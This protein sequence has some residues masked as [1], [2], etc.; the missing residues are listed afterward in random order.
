[1]NWRITY[2]HLGYKQTGSLV[3]NLLKAD[4][5]KTGTAAGERANGGLIESCDISVTPGLTPYKIQVEVLELTEFTKQKNS[6][7]SEANVDHTNSNKKS[8]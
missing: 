6:V 1:M 8:T 7:Q 2:S 5:P 4:D 3:K